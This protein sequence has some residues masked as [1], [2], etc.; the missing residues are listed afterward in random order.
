M[1]KRVV[2]VFLAL[3]IAGFASAQTKL[4]GTQQCKAEPPTPTAIPDSPNHAFAIIKATCTWTTPI[5]IAGLQGKD[6]DDIVS[7]EMWGD[8]GADRGYFVGTM[9]NG[10]K[11]TVKFSG[12]S[13]SKDGKPVGGQGT[14]SFSGA[15]GKL[16]GLKGKGTYTG[17]ANADGTTTYKIEGDYQLP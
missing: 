3:A 5:E 10:D 1:R 2:L 14:W 4:S 7:S 9:S 15:T 6:G 11:I 12:S 8:K 13:R 17:E 16:K